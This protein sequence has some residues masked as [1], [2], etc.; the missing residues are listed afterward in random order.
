MKL[1]NVFVHQR[2]PEIL[3]E[4]HHR[5]IKNDRKPNRVEN[6]YKPALAEGV[7]EVDEKL[8]TDE[9]S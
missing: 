1:E 7:K 3:K 6:I 5:S 4:T 8:I 9:V 2:E